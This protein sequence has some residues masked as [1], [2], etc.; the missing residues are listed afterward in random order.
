MTVFNSFDTI[1]DFLNRMPTKNEACEAAA[2]AHQ[3]N[4][5]KPPGSLG[6]LEEL[7]VFL[8]GW[9][10]AEKPSLDKAQAII[11]AGNH[12]ICAQ[13][14][15]PFPQEVTHLMV[16]NFDAGGAAMNQLCAVSGAALN[17]VPLSLDTPT[18]DFTQ[19]QALS[20]DALFEAMS[21]GAQAVDTSANILL[22]GE[23]GIGNSTI[24]S[25]LAACVFGGD[26][27]SWVGI[28]TGSDADGVARKVD[29]IEKGLAKHGARADLSALLAFGGREQAAIC[30]AILAAR[31]A[32]IPVMLDGFICTAAAAP[33]YGLNPA[34][35]DHCL[36]AHKSVEP[37]HQRLLEK[38]DKQAILDL[39]MRLGEGT[40]S[41]LAL[42]ILRGAVACHNQ[43]ATF[44]SAGIA[45]A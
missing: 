2:L 33:L 41:A 15:N 21:A 6:R 13:G 39:N 45:G 12:G 31:A 27:A 42:N 43:M 18:G 24:S 11:F 4:L 1:S 9:Q 7:A 25:A 36:V 35:L 32:R 5:T 17:V 40:G 14:V 10:E 23:M 28:G 38:M 34:S 19:T 44:E 16:A 8:A 20:E 30:G 37:G 22:L 3:N 26:V 29:V